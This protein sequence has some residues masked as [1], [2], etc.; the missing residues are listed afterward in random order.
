MGLQT[1]L[2]PQTPY[3]AYGKDK[4]L[5]IWIL[6]LQRSKCIPIDLEGT[7]ETFDC[8]EITTFDQKLPFEAESVT[9][10]SVD[11]IQFFFKCYNS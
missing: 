6:F 11:H 2:L 10:G 1:S 7:L 5:K 4:K 9:M 3:I 8:E